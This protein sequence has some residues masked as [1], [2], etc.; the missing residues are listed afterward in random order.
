MYFQFLFSGCNTEHVNLRRDCGCFGCNK[1]FQ[2]SIFYKLPQGVDA[3]KS[4]WN[5]SNYFYDFGKLSVSFIKDVFKETKK[6]LN[7]TDDFGYYPF[8]YS[9]DLTPQK[10]IECFRNTV[11]EMTVAKLKSQS[12]DQKQSSDQKSDGVVT[13]ENSEDIFF[14]QKECEE[15][16]AWLNKNLKPQTDNTTDFNW[17]YE[18]ATDSEY[19]KYG[20]PVLSYCIYFKGPATYRAMAYFRARRQAM[21]NAIANG[22][23]DQ[24]KGDTAR[25]SE[26]FGSGGP[27]A[28]FGFKQQEDAR[29]FPTDSTFWKLLKQNPGL[30]LQSATEYKDEKDAKPHIKTETK[31]EPQVQQV[32][33]EQNQPKP[34]ISLKTKE[35]K[36]DTSSSSSDVKDEKYH[37]LPELKEGDIEVQKANSIHKEEWEQATGVLHRT[38][39]ESTNVAIRRFWKK[40]FEA[41]KTSTETILKH[42]G[43]F[44]LPIM[45]VNSNP[46]DGRPYTVSMPVAGSLDKI[47]K[48]KSLDAKS[49]IRILYDVAR[50]IE[51]L[52]HLS[53]E[54]NN[55]ALR[56]EIIADNI[57]L[58]EQ[59]EQLWKDF[60]PCNM[61]D[62]PALGL[63]GENSENS[64]GTVKSKVWSELK[65]ENDLYNNPPNFV[66]TKKIDL[67]KMIWQWGLLAF[68]VWSGADWGGSYFNNKDDR[69]R[70]VIDRQKPRYNHEA[71]TLYN[72]KW[73][74]QAKQG[75]AP[76][77]LY[78]LVQAGCWN[79]NIN[80]RPSP[81]ELVQIMKWIYKDTLAEVHTDDSV[82]LTQFIMGK[83]LTPPIHQ[84][85]MT[86]GVT[87]TSPFQKPK[88]NN[89]PKIIDRFQA[90]VELIYPKRD[91]TAEDLNQLK[92][93]FEDR[94]E[95]PDW[96]DRMWAIK[97]PNCAHIFDKDAKEV[98]AS[99]D[100]GNA[101]SI[102]FG[103]II[104]SS[105][106]APNKV[107]V[108]ETKMDDQN[109]AFLN[110]LMAKL[111][112]DKPLK[113]ICDEKA[114]SNGQAKRR[115]RLD[116]DIY[117]SLENAKYGIAAELAQAFSKVGIPAKAI[118]KD[119]FEMLDIDS[120]NLDAAQLN[121]H[122]TAEKLQNEVQVFKPS[123][124][125]LFYL[126]GLLLKEKNKDLA[127]AD[128]M[129]QKAALL[130]NA[131]AAEKIKHEDR[132]PGGIGFGKKFESTTAPQNKQ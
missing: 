46:K 47:F 111:F 25:V 71:Q 92:A 68:E 5:G 105:S 7:I 50:F 49:R 86:K 31:D 93:K 72:K 70:I 125:G 120:E 61:D 17:A 2:V 102:N 55:L 77:G 116:L 40:D 107:E 23:P 129:F 64:G 3:D 43:R 112:P 99:N 75:A 101:A 67:P 9:E 103:G 114:T 126:G 78:E 97:Y 100:K 37:H 89:E 124:A 90:F 51:A 29:Y 85:I 79:K 108:K 109:L 113:F 121:S 123:K 118:V 60:K 8:R 13:Q 110:D 132:A 24:G 33:V 45:G 28:R 58:L 16:V 69:E 14:E 84:F 87:P 36:L 6:K 82:P 76:N 62:E 10:I 81:K 98:K 19:Q 131:A 42:A 34:S 39:T 128:R 91:E 27:L 63:V 65:K 94:P 53:D 119:K 26:F 48:T 15:L 38:V 95:S 88:D 59:W 4:S 44:Y 54:E 1:S 20:L 57:L 32:N 80:N 35:S 52:S 122:S 115:Y 104:K 83:D 66:P 22:N 73:M 11:I 18:E 41:H 74:G 127:L 130:G 21:E 56:R 30:L 12:Q 117:L 96:I 106:V